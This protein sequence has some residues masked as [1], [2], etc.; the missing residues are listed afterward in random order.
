MSWKVFEED[1][2]ELASLGFE[3]LNRKIAYLAIIEKDGSP[4][5]HPVTPFIGND[6]LFI[7][8]EPSS[9]K[10]RD[11]RRDA[12]YALHCSVGGEGPLIEVLVSGKATVISDPIVRAQAERIAASPVVTDSYV[13]F[14]FQ[15]KRVLVV[16]YDEE[17]KPVVRR[18]STEKTD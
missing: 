13:L 11:L 15:V 16:E 10:I 8:T 5:L 6:M 14:E 12:R 18:W 1:A 4:R 9:P 17:G 2:P 7:F 3:K